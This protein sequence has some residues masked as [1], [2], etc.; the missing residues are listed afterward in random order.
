[1]TSFVLVYVLILHFSI[2]IGVC[3][4]IP[5]SDLAW[6]MVSFCQ[7]STFDRDFWD[8]FSDIK[9]KLSVPLGFFGNFFDLIFRKKSK[10]TPL[11]FCTKKSQKSEKIKGY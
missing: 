8:F 4:N 7:F 3:Q 1:M 11:E 10:G 2:T 6:K 9:K 5:G